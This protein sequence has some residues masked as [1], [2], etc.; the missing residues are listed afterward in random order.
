MNIYI[1]ICIYKYWAAYHILCIAVDITIFSDPNQDAMWLET[2]ACSPCMAS[3][4][5]RE[6][7]FL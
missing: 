6:M 5:V 2:L 3:S 7:H 1:Y 4:H